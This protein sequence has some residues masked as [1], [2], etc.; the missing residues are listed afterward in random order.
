MQSLTS[1]SEECSLISTLV[2]YEAASFKVV[3]SGQ[4]IGWESVGEHS[5]KYFENPCIYK[6]KTWLFIVCHRPKQNNSNVTFYWMWAC[7]W[8]KWS[9]LAVN[10]KSHKLNT[11]ISSLPCPSRHS[12]HQLVVSASSNVL[13]F[14]Y[15]IEWVGS[16]PNI[17]IFATVILCYLLKWHKPTSLDNMLLYRA[18]I[19]I[20][21][22][23]RCLDLFLL[24]R[25]LQN[26]DS[27]SNFNH[28]FLYITP[29]ISCLVP[30]Q[31]CCFL[32][33]LEEF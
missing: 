33:V 28:L 15:W 7:Q 21:S 25:W 29:L 11:I 27:F 8:L 1:N 14:L 24:S 16:T 30:L 32:T 4:G 3:I 18:Q 26:L 5:N 19:R 22:L 17:T 31:M 10:S 9:Y 20:S 13:P 23:I 12:F 2:F 6:A